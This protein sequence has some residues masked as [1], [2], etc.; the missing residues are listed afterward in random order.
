MWKA[1]RRPTSW[2][3]VCDLLD[4]QE[5]DLC[6]PC[7]SGAALHPPTCEQLRREGAPKGAAVHPL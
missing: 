5:D 3:H 1:A 2:N 4:P 6:R 7:E